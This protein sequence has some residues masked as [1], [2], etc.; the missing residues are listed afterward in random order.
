MA[1]LHY[2]NEGGKE[3]DRG[4]SGSQELFEDTL[5]TQ[6]LPPISD[7]VSNRKTTRSLHTSSL[8]DMLENG[9]GTKRPV[10]S[11]SDPDLYA[12][13]QSQA[14]SGAIWPGRR[15]RPRLQ[16]AF[17]SPLSMSRDLSISKPL[18]TNHMIADSPENGIRGQTLQSPNRV[19][20][21]EETNNKPKM[22]GSPEHIEDTMSTATTIRSPPVMLPLS[23][24]IRPRRSIPTTFRRGLSTPNPLPPYVSGSTAIHLARP[25]R[26]YFDRM[27][28]KE[29]KVMV[30]RNV[31]DRGPEQERDRR[32]S[33]EVGARR[34]LIKLS[35]VR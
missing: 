16:P 10:P 15:L 5:P 28:P 29:L 27:L 12:F 17:T 21:S 3:F 31:L 24:P 6:E 19:G 7:V 14:G 25:K 32:W 23:N 33:G 30:M 1:V 2:S 11:T 22:N 9:L 34:E 18:G 35:R 26:N 20:N 13:A 8:R 4:T